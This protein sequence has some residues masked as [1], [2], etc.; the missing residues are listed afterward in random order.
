MGIAFD[1]ESRRIVATSGTT[2]LDVREVYSRWKEWVVTSENAKWPQAFRVV[3]GDSIGGGNS[4]APY[5]FLQNGW[6]LRPQEASHTLIITGALLV[7]G[8]G[9]PVVPTL[10]DWRVLV[11]HSVP[12]RAEAVSTSGGG[13]GGDGA[14][15]EQIASAV[16][17]ALV[18][19]NLASGSAGESLA[20]AGG[21]SAEQVGWLRLAQQGTAVARCVSFTATPGAPGVRVLGQV[22][23]APCSARAVVSAGV[24]ARASPRTVQVWVIGKNGKP[25]LTTIRV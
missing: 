25:K 4:V 2:A 10:G 8:G 17:A 21:L 5:F 22:T 12:V 9:D 20:R 16:W 24:V 14:S 11:Q 3:G 23:L 18:A 19:G 15:A 13:G 6:R 7:D 1:G